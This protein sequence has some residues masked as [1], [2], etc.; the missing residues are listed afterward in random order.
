MTEIGHLRSVFTDRRL[1]YTRL[2][3]YVLDG[4]STP[5]AS[6]HWKRD[7]PALMFLFLFFKESSYFLAYI[8]YIIPPDLDLAFK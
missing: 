4:T 5:K 1:V 7:N 6:S 2:N 8:R 3:N